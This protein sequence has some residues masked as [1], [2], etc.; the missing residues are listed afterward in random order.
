MKLKKAMRLYP[1]VISNDVFDHV[2]Y[3]I[4]ERRI[5]FNVTQNTWKGLVDENAASEGEIKFATEKEAVKWLLTDPEDVKHPNVALKTEFSGKGIT[6]S[7]FVS[8][9]EKKGRLPIIER[10]LASD[11]MMHEWHKC[12]ICGK[13]HRL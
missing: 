2:L 4:G 8:F 9:L 10:F 5:W 11:K 7:R 13:Y 6:D 1:I 12:P 3:K